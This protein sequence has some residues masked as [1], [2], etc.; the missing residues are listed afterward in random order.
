MRSSNSDG[1]D[2][3]YVSVTP[4]VN[5]TKVDKKS[6]PLSDRDAQ[7]FQAIEEEMLEKFPPTTDEKRLGLRAP[8][9]KRK[10][11]GK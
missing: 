4:P 3:L 7:L 2:K 6:K 5:E 11:S 1:T 10:H 8:R 9:P